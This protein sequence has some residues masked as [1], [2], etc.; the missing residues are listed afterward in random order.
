MP[1]ALGVSST[2]YLLSDRVTLEGERT[3]LAL[4]ELALWRSSSS[5]ALQ[6]QAKTTTRFAPFWP[7]PA[8]LAPFSES[9]AQ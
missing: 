5:R 4:V 3:P 7:H 8:S 9:T 6:G 1:L 2:T